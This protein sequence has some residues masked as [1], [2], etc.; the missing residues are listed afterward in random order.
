MNHF[1]NQLISVLLGERPLQIAMQQAQ[2]DANQQIR[3]AE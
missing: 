2:D 3:A 1:N